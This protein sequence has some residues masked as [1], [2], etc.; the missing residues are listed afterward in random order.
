MSF[1]LSEST[2]ILPRRLFLILRIDENTGKLT[3]VK[4]IENIFL[5]NSTSNR[6]VKGIRKEEE[7]QQAPSNYSTH[8]KKC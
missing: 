4:S 8:M 6:H 1:R 2:A 3:E 7:Q 5:D